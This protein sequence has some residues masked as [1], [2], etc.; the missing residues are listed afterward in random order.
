MLQELNELG[1]GP[2]TSKTSCQWSTLVNL[3]EAGKAQQELRALNLTEVADT[4]FEVG[5]WRLGVNR[6]AATETM[7]DVILK[8]ILK[9]SY[10]A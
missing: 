2:S 8:I 6:C 5:L 4:P 3:A 7:V 1:Y 10:A 9:D